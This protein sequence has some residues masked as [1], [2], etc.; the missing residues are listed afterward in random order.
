MLCTISSICI[1]KPLG[2][3]LSTFISDTQAL[4]LEELKV[5]GKILCVEKFIDHSNIISI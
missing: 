1:I 3:L 5:D 2:L 4:T